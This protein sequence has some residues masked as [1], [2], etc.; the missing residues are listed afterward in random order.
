MGGANS[1][2]YFNRQRKPQLCSTMADFDGSTSGNFVEV[3]AQIYPT[4]VVLWGFFFDAIRA[5][6]GGPSGKALSVCV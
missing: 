5:T 6:A 4:I 2:P 3:L 1:G